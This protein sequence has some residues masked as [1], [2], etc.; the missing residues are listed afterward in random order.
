[1]KTPF[2]KDIQKIAELNEMTEAEVMLKW[3]A[4]G[5]LYMDNKI[6]TP[7]NITDFQK[8]YLR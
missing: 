4:Y 7:P 6:I 8:Y 1:M 3:S 2:E 5:F